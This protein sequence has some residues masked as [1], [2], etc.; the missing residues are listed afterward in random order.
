M[1]RDQGRVRQALHDI[2][3]GIL[4]VTLA[5][6]HSIKCDITLPT[7]SETD[8][9]YVNQVI[10]RQQELASSFRSFMTMGQSFGKVNENR[11]KFY[12]EVIG[13]AR[14]VKFSLLHH[15][16]ALTYPFKFNSHCKVG[17]EITTGSPAQYVD[18]TGKG[19]HSAA[20]ALHDFVDPRGL[21]KYG[22][23]RRPLVVLSFDES[24]VLTD[25]T[26][27]SE[28]ST[29]SELRRILQRL[30]G[31]LIFSLFL[32]TSGNFRMLSPD[33]KPDPSSRVV[34]EALL[35]FHP[36]TDVSF[37]C[38]ARPAAEGSMTLFEVTQIDWI[39]H[40]GRPLYVPFIHCLGNLL[41]CSCTVDLVLTLTCCPRRT[42]RAKSSILPSRSC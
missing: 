25:G 29:F 10:R 8:S 5:H 33:I 3:Y 1:P 9:A 19:V 40:L 36:I 34:N 20:K 2:V 41:V 23:W 39:A 27:E 7:K 13:A 18:Q 4:T 14:A 22:Q 21:V 11:Q 28:W 32:S 24:H 42:E 31:H 6:L 17:S 26:K 12:G 38:L 30:G 35:P 15:Y 16:C 37:D